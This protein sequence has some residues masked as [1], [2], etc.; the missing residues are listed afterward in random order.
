[1][2]SELKNDQAQ[3]R[4]RDSP[5]LSLRPSLLTAIVYAYGDKNEAERMWSELN[6]QAQYRYRDEEFL[7]NKLRW[8]DRMINTLREFKGLYTPKA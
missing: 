3:Y 1:M 7:R 4:H 2:W 8:P 5:P 6:G